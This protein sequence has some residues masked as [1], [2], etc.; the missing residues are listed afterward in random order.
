MAMNVVIPS[1]LPFFVVVQ[2]MAYCGILTMAE[3]ILAPFFKLLRLN[4]KCAT[5]LI[6]SFLAGYPVGCK[7]VVEM[8]KENM[9][10]KEEAEEFLSFCNNGGIIFCISVCG[11]EVFSDYRVGVFMFCVQVFSSLVTGIIMSREKGGGEI[12]RKERKIGLMASLGKG[13]S[14]GG[15]VLMN[16]IASF[17]VFYAVVNAFSLEN[18]PF[19]CSFAEVTKGILWAGEMKS[20]PLGA[21]FLSF[22]GFAVF[23]Q[24][25]ALMAESDL[26][27]K[28]MVIGKS[29]SAVISFFISWMILYISGL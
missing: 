22:G 24:C 11:R 10:T 3:N 19:L 28:K 26:S 21:M 13:I 2:G 15:S 5:P 16:I 4:K 29:F 7:I 9:I 23:A 14:M 20:I 25:A 1:I 12:I 18:V 8:Y 6:T 17:I 27:I